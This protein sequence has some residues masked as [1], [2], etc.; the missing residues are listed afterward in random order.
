VLACVSMFHPLSVISGS[1][2]GVRC[3]ERADV[4]ETERTR[5]GGAA[6]WRVTTAE[7]RCNQ[8]ASSGLAKV[9]PRCPDRG[10]QAA[11]LIAGLCSHMYE[12]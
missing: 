9:V 5:G 6:G 4:C 7:S 12:Y 3:H 11:I 8:Y 10:S 2:H 1:L